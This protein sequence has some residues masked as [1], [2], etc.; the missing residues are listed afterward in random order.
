[1]GAENSVHR[2]APEGVDKA[3]FYELIPDHF[4]EG[5][6]NELKGPNGLISISTLEE[7][8]KRVTDVFLFSLTTGALTSLGDR[9]THVS[10]L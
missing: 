2:V 10:A 9:I 4:S 7:F 5:L 3:K 6:F 1:M 8:S